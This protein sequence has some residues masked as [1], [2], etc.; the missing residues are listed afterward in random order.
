MS[1]VEPEET[2][3][4]TL[5]GLAALSDLPRTGWLL[6]GVNPCESIA[7]HSFFVALLA[8]MMVD[9]LRAEG[10]EI[11]G[12]RTLRMALCHD[13]VEARTGDVPMPA[14]TPAL[15]EGLRILESRLAEEVLCSQLLDDWKEYEGKASLEARV[16]KAADKIQM[17][18]QV[19]VY[20]SQGRGHLQE[21][22]DNP[23][24]FRTMD[25]PLAE[26]IYRLICCKAGRPVPE[27]LR[28]LD[29]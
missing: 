8:A 26:R 13:A 11:D 22:W 6:R 29:A 25:L 19:L 24:N 12:E 27:H 4:Q 7:A 20:E 10:K 3:V 23:K 5:M 1:R 9:A 18:V 15:E 16:V 28:S 21:F 17:M 14:K 2:I